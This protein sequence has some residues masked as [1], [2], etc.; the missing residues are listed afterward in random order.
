[1]RLKLPFSPAPQV[2]EERRGWRADFDL[3]KVRWKNGEVEGYAGMMA[4]IQAFRFGEAGNSVRFKLKY[5]DLDG[6][7]TKLALELAFESESTIIGQ[8]TKTDLSTYP[9]LYNLLLL[10]DSELPRRSK[11]T[12]S[13]FQSVHEMN[14]Q[15]VITKIIMSLQGD[16]DADGGTPPVTHGQDHTAEEEEGGDGDGDGDG[17]EETE[18]GYDFTKTNSTILEKSKALLHE[19]FLQA[20]AMGYRPGFTPVSD[21]WVISLSIPLRMVDIDPNT[22]AMW[23]D[24]LVDAWKADKQ[25]TLLVQVEGYPPQLD[26]MTFHLG[27]FDHYKPSLEEVVAATRGQSQGFYLSQ[28][29]LNYLKDFPRCYKLRTGFDSNWDAA[30]K[31][32]LD[33]LEC[34]MVFN[35]N[36]MPKASKKWDEKD[37]IVKGLQDNLPVVAFWWV[38]RRFTEA[39]KYCLVRTRDLQ[40]MLIQNCG[41]QVAIPSLRPYVCDSPLCLYGFMSL[42]L[43]PSIEHVIRTQPGV[44]DLLLSFAHA[45]ASSSARMDLP[46]GLQ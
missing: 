27:F 13:R 9:H 34:R 33:E 1:M 39:T 42:G 14:L 32:G 38:L 26:N 41:L 36:Q 46:M 2:F 29:L 25:F 43:G 16:D 24:G 28:P 4:S 45:S 44:V 7:A 5:E 35:E 21:F 19:H 17:W 37:P 22:L 23:D 11:S 6:R 15:T 12:F 3:C 30:D 20:K 18:R 40:Q 10:T 31:I 8:L